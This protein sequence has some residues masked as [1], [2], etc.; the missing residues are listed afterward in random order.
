MDTTHQ[1][2]ELKRLFQELGGRI[3]NE[4]AIR[5]GEI[6]IEID[7]YR[8]HLY[9]EFSIQPHGRS[10][11]L[12]EPDAEFFGYLVGIVGK[13]ISMVE[14][15][16]DSHLRFFIEDYCEIYYSLNRPELDTPEL[17]TVTDIR[18]LDNLWVLPNT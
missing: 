7:G 16:A 11:V 3:V 12:Q 5:I 8:L 2:N 9:F 13:R 15:E 1:S 18:D 17:G 10:L 14:F 6:G 4:V